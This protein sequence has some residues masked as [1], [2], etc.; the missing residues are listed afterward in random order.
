MK[1]TILF[2]ATAKRWFDKV[3]GNTYHSVRVVR[4]SD[5]EVLFCPFQYGYGD[6]YRYTA[7]EAMARAGWLP[8]E[9]TVPL[10]SGGLNVWAYERENNY[11]ILWNVSDGL[12]RDCVANGRHTNG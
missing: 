5:G 2:T 6:Q 9:Y 1:R 12:K 7:L 3:N 4:H 11:P 10:V 8:E